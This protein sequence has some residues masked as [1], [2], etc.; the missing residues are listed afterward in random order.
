VSAVHAF[1]DN[2]F[3]VDV[4]D[5]QQ[6]TNY[7]GADYGI[8]SQTILQAEVTSDGQ[9]W[10][11]T[12]PW[13]SNNKYGSDHAVEIINEEGEAY[14]VIS[15]LQVKGT[16]GFIRSLDADKHGNI[17]ASVWTYEDD[18]PGLEAGL[19]MHD[20]E[21]WQ[22]VPDQGVDL[23]R[24]VR[25]R[26]DDQG[27][28][29]IITECG[30]VMSY[31]G[32][33]W[34]V[35]IEEN[36]SPVCSSEDKYNGLYLDDNG[37][38]WLW[39]HD[40]VHM[41]NDGTWISFTVENS[42]LSEIDDAVGGIFGVVVD[43]QNQLWVASS[44]GVTMIPV[45]DSKPLPDEIVRTNRTMQ[46]LGINWFLAS[47][48]MLLWVAV[49]FNIWP[50]VLVAV[51]I[52]ILVTNWIGAPIE[53]PGDYGI[54]ELNPGVLV[55]FGG[56]VGGSIG[57]QIDKGREADGASNQNMNFVLAFIGL[58]LGLVCYFPLAIMSSP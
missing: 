56:M 54:Y 32:R 28:A 2:V 18:T 21:S 27:N 49:Y 48:L 14:G 31:D 42:G 20:G 38:L 16:D 5:G 50:G 3:G 35:V 47:V 7:A 43:E 12:N 46:S 8:K 25:T 33:A 22:K 30:G 55:T 10:I 9:I 4:F 29:W 53:G 44:G 11:T 57:G 24:V 52:G 41:L 37:R 19:Y 6:W 17:W 13:G 39:Q 40:S 58:V 51:V 15:D 45:E 36:D 1:G 26:F 34:T 23:R